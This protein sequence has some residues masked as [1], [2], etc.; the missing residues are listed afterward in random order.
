[1][2]DQEWGMTIKQE[3]AQETQRKMD[4]YS[5]YMSEPVWIFE[6]LGVDTSEDP[7]LVKR[8][9]QALEYRDTKTIGEIIFQ[10]IEAAA[11]KFAEM[12]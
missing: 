10:E 9:L 8:F 11:M 3:A 6:E 7:E 4:R 12:D 2:I 1:M 5:D